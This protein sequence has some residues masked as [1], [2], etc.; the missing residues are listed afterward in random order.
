MD[1]GAYVAGYAAASFV[2]N[3]ASVCYGLPQ[4]D[5]VLQDLLRRLEPSQV[6]TSLISELQVKLMCSSSAKSVKC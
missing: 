5:Q 3:H 6:T 2:A 4:P 1:L